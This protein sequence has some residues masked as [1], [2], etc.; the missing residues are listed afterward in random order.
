MKK[1]KKDIMNSYR[2]SLFK[3]MKRR[4]VGGAGAG[5]K[6]DVHEYN[7]GNFMLS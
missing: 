5:E 2:F 3:V 4:G 6:N 7:V 1:Y